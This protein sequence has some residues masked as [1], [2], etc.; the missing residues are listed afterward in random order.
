MR[1][2]T[3]VDDAALGDLPVSAEYDGVGI[4]EAPELETLYGRG[5]SREQRALI[6][7]D[8]LRVFDRYTPQFSFYCTET[9]V[10]EGP[11]GEAVVFRY[12]YRKAKVSR[13]AFEKHLQGEHAQLCVEAANTLG[14]LR[15]ALNTT[16][17]A[18]PATSRLKRSTNA[19]SRQSTTPQ[20]RLPRRRRL[21]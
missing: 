18:P 12:L 19:G 21:G 9:R 11:L 16:I 3:R 4:A 2:T 1:Y 15:W 5:F 6:D 20:K 8:E 10:L 14:A 13:D 17:D 7:Q